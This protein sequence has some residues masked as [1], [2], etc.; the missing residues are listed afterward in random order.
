MESRLYQHRYTI[1][2]G[3][4]LLSVILV[5]VIPIGG[6]VLGYVSQ[7][8]SRLLI[9]GLGA[10]GTILLATL[11]VLTI[12]NN[13]VLINERLKDREKPIQTAVLRDVVESALTTVDSN[14]SKILHCEVNWVDVSFE[15]GQTDLLG[16]NL[17]TCYDDPDAVAIERFAQ[18][19]PETAQ[20]VS[21]YD[22]RVYELSNSARDLVKELEDPVS[23]FRLNTEGIT[24]NDHEQ[25][26][27]LLLSVYEGTNK[28]DDNLPNWW[29]E[30]RV[31]A[32]AAAMEA[33]PEL[34]HWYEEQ[35]NFLDFSGKVQEELIEV[36]RE[37]QSEYGIDLEKGSETG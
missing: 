21:E 27:R 11:T 16:V 32:E 29:I 31:E 14:R 28:Q 35:E 18:S 20:L 8:V 9:A 22:D 6:F 25:L 30:H 26:M 13:Q 3:A 33:V 17:E 12:L 4:L 24:E 37:I 19:Y 36:K 7:T 1:A 10:L 23:E 15:T 2:V 5:L 34:G